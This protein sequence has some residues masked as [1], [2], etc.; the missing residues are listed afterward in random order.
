M[1]FAEKIGRYAGTIVVL[2][3]AAALSAVIIALGVKIV[4]WLL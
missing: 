1:K 2:S 3:I 4:L